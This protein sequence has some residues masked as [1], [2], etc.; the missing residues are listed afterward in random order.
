MHSLRKPW[1]SKHIRMAGRGRESNLKQRADWVQ[2]FMYDSGCSKCGIF[3][4]HHY[5]NAC[6][7][8][9]VPPP[10][11][12]V[13]SCVCVPSAQKYVVFCPL[14]TEEG[15]KEGSDV[16][17][18][19]LFLAFPPLSHLSPSL[20]AYED[21]SVCPLLLGEGGNNFFGHYFSLLFP[22]PTLE[23]HE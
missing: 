6:N 12:H 9:Y 20:I 7:L 4:I 14:Q 16:L 3:P 21:E 10:I 13:L 19:L 11:Q 15:R 18:G 22:D 1:S 5:A 23:V 17:Q 2:S 8:P